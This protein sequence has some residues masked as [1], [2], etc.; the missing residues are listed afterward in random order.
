MTQNSAHNSFWKT[1]DAMIV[2]IF[3]A[4][5]ILEYFVIDFGNLP[6][7]LPLR[8]SLG[9]ILIFVGLLLIILAKIEFSKAQQP[10]MP[11]KPTT[12]IVNTGIF[13]Y[14]RNPLY[15][16]IVITVAGVGITFDIL[17]FII[18]DIPL[19]MLFHWTLI[20]PEEQYL[21]EK[22]GND[23]ELYIKNTRRWL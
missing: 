2:I 8:L 4:G 20:M 23:Y 16:G 19:G 3:S 14:S 6:F 13:K 1:T 5:F 10:S 21:L 7:T 12:R 15:L 11:G 9:G 22:F 18:L 17:W